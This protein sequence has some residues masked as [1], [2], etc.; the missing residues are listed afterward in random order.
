MTKRYEIS[1][2]VNLIRLEKS[3]SIEFSILEFSDV[4]NGV[5]KLFDLNA[6]QKTKL[7]MLTKKY[8]FT[9]RF[10]IMKFD[11]LKFLNTHIFA[12]I[13]CVIVLH[14]IDMKTIYQK[15]FVLKNCLVFTD[16]VRKIK[17]IKQYR[18]L[19]KILKQQQFAQWI[20]NWEKIYD[21]IIKIN[22]F[23][24]DSILF[25]YNF[26]NIIC[27]IEKAYIAAQKS[28]IEYAINC[29]DIVITMKELLENYQ[30]HVRLIKMLIETEKKISH[31]TFAIL[32]GK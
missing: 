2:Y 8:K 7:N 32:Q 22:I 5:T 28:L 29:D 4:L 27:L 30:N 1:D 10:I 18:F 11:V 9:S 20:Q 14:L 25:L 24:I 15:F 17:V 19:Q 16:R 12:T 13:N 6:N 26:L 21:E 23:D 31:L 3:K